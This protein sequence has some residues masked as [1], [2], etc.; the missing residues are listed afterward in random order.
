[1]LYLECESEFG[2]NPSPPIKKQAK[3]KRNVIWVQKGRERGREKHFV[4]AE[5]E[6]KKMLTVLKSFSSTCALKAQSEHKH[7]HKH[8]VLGDLVLLNFL[9][10]TKL[11]EK[12]GKIDFFWGW[13]GVKVQIQSYSNEHIALKLRKY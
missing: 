13:G 10:C 12:W 7:K 3:L 8:N 6:I 1:M 9:E 11:A 4:G 5:E 2:S